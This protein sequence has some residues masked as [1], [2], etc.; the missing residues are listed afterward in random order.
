MVIQFLNSYS[1]I[2]VKEITQFELK[3]NL[4]LPDE[5]KNFLL[6]YNGGDTKPQTYI[7][8]AV[9][10]VDEAIWFFID[11]FY[12]LLHDE[13]VTWTKSLQEIND[14]FRIEFEDWPENMLIIGSLYDGH[15]HILIDVLGQTKGAIYILSNELANEIPL[16]LAD[17]FEIFLSKIKYNP[18]KNES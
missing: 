2:T 9:E 12:G 1:Q 6:A 7:E 16:K 14:T 18:I 10:G 13:G 3:N 11:R 5:Y 17:S 8:V 4:K 15:H